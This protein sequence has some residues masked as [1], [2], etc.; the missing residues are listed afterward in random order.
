MMNGFRASFPTNR[1]YSVLPANLSSLPESVNW[2][3]KGAVTEVKDQKYCGCC[4][5]FSATGGL[6]GAY[7]KKYNK[8]VSLSEQQ[9]LDCNKK[10]VLIQ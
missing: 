9:L 1:S 6:E 2:V 10:M 7:F 5:A 4:W 3:E 8:L